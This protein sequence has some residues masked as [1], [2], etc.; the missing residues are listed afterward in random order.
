MTEW[1]NEWMNVAHAASAEN[2]E[3]LLKQLKF[4]EKSKLWL[5]IK[6]NVM[7]RKNGSS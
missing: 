6:Q 3:I 1:L 2:F 7:F 5:L 4:L